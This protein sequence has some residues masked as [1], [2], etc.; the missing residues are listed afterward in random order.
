MNFFCS[1]GNSYESSD[2]S[3]M[4]TKGPPNQARFIGGC[5]INNLVI[6][7]GQV[8][9]EIVSVEGSFKLNGVCNIG[10][11]ECADRSDFY[12]LPYGSEPSITLSISNLIGKDI[13]HNDS[14]G[15]TTPIT[16]I[17]TAAIF[18]Y[19]AG[20]WTAMIGNNIMD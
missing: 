15:Y 5:K 1:G 9:N 12:I 16:G 19:S 17:Y 10:I 14:N 13:L 18:K 3:I 2:D 6:K 7:D 20:N 11:L 4:G 8:G